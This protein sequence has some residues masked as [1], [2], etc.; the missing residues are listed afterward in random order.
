MRYYRPVQYQIKLLVDYIIGLNYLIRL[1]IAIRL[2]SD[3]MTK[4]NN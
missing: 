4:L 1:D 3:N 2:W